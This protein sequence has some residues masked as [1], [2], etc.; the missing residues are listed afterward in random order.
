MDQERRRIFIQQWLHRTGRS[1][2]VDFKVRGMLASV[3]RCSFQD[4][5]LWD[6]HFQQSRK[7]KFIFL[8]KTSWPFKQHSGRTAQFQFFH[9]RLFQTLRML[10]LWRTINILAATLMKHKR[11]DHS[12]FF[13]YRLQEERHFLLTDTKAIQDLLYQGLQQFCFI[14]I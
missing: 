13:L 14:R 7:E 8:F 1:F 5:F 10:S 2:P 3:Q 11:I 4:L 6:I 9:T 12:W